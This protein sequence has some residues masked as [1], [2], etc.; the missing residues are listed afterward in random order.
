MVE[1]K[2]HLDLTEIE[3]IFLNTLFA[4]MVANANGYEATQE[5]VENL[6]I[7]LADAM[8]D[9]EKRTLNIKMSK[10]VQGVSTELLE[11]FSIKGRYEMGELEKKYDEH[12]KKQGAR[13]N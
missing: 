6:L 12:F 13:Y 4:M 8:S 5:G 7:A 10:I 1:E 2:I 9:D 11:R 3:A